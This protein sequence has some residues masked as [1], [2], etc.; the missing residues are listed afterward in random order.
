VILTWSDG[1]RCY[2]PPFFWEKEFQAL[3]PVTVLPLGSATK[4]RNWI[5]I[6]AAREVGNL[7]KSGTTFH[8]KPGYGFIRHDNNSSGG[9]A[10]RVQR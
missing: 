9:R 7:F 8:L 5:E 3:S 10:G 1:A 6:Y 2:S 4:D